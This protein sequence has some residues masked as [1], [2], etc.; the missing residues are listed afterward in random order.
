M[1]TKVYHARELA[2]GIDVMRWSKRHHD[3]AHKNTM[4]VIMAHVSDDNFIA[5]LDQLDFDVND[6]KKSWWASMDVWMRFY[7]VCGRIYCTFGASLPS[8]WAGNRYMEADNIWSS[9]R[10]DKESKQFRY[11]DNTDKEDGVT[12]SEW[13]RRKNVWDAVYAKYG[14]FN[15]G[16]LLLSVV[17]PSSFKDLKIEMQILRKNRLKKVAP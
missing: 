6:P 3:T 8:S 11:W 2:P 5:D 16:T 1:S 9:L 15:S 17:S 4:R 7:E 14:C 13:T 12:N 10:R